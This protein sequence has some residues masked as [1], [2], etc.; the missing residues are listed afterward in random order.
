MKKSL[1]IFLVALLTLTGCSIYINGNNQTDAPPINTDASLNYEYEIVDKSTG[2]YIA[3]AEEQN[4]TQSFMIELGKKINEEYKNAS[5]DF[6]LV[7]HIYNNQAAMEMQPEWN[8]GNT[9]KEEDD[10]YSKHYLGYYEVGGIDEHGYEEAE[11]HILIEEE[12]GLIQDFYDS[13]YIGF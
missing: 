13:R 11:F 6:G 12:Y 10:F 5:K 9:T 7:I 4:I 8:I 1:F 3:I 2:V